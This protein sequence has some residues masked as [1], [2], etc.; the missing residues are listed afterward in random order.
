MNSTFLRS[1]TALTL[2]VA[3]PAALSAFVFAAEPATKPAGLTPPAALELDGVPPIP[4]A[5]AEEANR[6]TEFRSASLAAWHPHERQMLIRTRFGATVQLHHVAMPL[7][8]RKQITFFQEPVGSAD[9]PPGPGNFHPTAIYFTKDVGGN[10]FAQIFKMDMQGDVSLLTDGTSRN[11]SPVFSEDGMKFVYTS[12]RRDKQNPDFYVASI[13]KPAEAKMVFQAPAPGW[14]PSDWSPD[15]TKLC[16][17][18]FSSANESALYLFDLATGKAERLSP[19]TPHKSKFSGGVFSANGLKV[20]CTTDVRGEFE[21]LA[22]IDVLT[23]EVKILTP[24][25]KWDVEDYSLSHDGKL[26]AFTTNEDG[27]AVLHLMDTATEKELPLPKLPPGEITGLSWHRNNRDLGMV[28]NSAKAP[29]DVF[30]LDVV[31]G[32]VTRWTE[33]ETAGLDTASFPD[34]TLVRWK[35]F[36][37]RQIS[38]FLY[39]PDAAKFPGKRPVI[40]NIHGGPES[41]FRPG[42]MGP[43]NYYF[44]KLGVAAIF[45][46]VRGSSG[47]GKTFLTL[48]DG[49][50]RE[51][52]VK[53]IGALLDWIKTQ[54]DLDAD[55]IMVTG[56]SYGGY[57]S[58]A[59]STHYAD[60]IRCS[61]DVVG[62][63]NF[64]TFLEKTEA[65]RRDLRR[66]EYGDERDPA[67]RKF[68]QDISPLNNVARIKKPLF[69]IHGANDPRVPVGEAR[70]I[71]SA[72]KAQGTPVWSLV[73]AD[74]GHGF[75]KKPNQQYQFY[76]MIAYIR[77]Y[78]L[79]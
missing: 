36:D 47:Y 68:Q 38:G 62:I 50:K 49:F 53:D 70:Q 22:T 76:A 63:S 19:P 77:E 13:D 14:Y 72:L 40:I 65:Y 43:Y 56:G 7:G 39:K 28:I 37:D 58:L 71:V 51:D 9:F 69:V 46:N 1:L 78:L 74:E 18:K 32:Q 60:R 12:T 16:G 54:P 61:V 35:S 5:V 25:L 30:S 42:F 21:Q 6:Y 15:G 11:S 57:M 20:Y 27:L 2:P 55:R 52:S 45:P 24:D 44:T 10:E 75:A 59:V 3:I 73:A 4:A 66:V 48:D 17:G 41:Q 79:K 34:P 67:M 64:V 31:T 26:L 33:S 29:S 23:R 8:A